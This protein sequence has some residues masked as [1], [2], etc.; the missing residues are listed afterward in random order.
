MPEPANNLQEALCEARRA[1]QSDRE[2]YQERTRQLEAERHALRAELHDILIQRMHGKMPVGPFFHGGPVGLHVGDTVLPPALTGLF[3]E[4][5]I[6]ENDYRVFVTSCYPKAVFY[7]IGR[8]L[9]LDAEVGKV[10]RVKPDGD[11]TPD[12]DDID[13]D[14]PNAFVC[15][16]AKVLEVISPTLDDIVSDVKPRLPRLL[17][18]TLIAPGLQD[19][20]KFASL[21]KRFAMEAPPSGQ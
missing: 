17:R 8:A 11:L 19:G 5:R 18:S 3:P 9:M 2:Q 20:L 12:P 10:Y 14:P 21:L 16:S 15:K 6:P 7:A 1:V 13:A 4:G